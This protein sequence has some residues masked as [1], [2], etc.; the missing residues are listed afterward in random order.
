MFCRGALF[1]VG[2][3]WISQ[4]ID[5][6]DNLFNRSAYVCGLLCRVLTACYM[7]ESSCI[8]LSLLGFTRPCG[9]SDDRTP[10]IVPTLTPTPSYSLGDPTS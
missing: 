1:R 6:A 10:T 2:E 9:F 7:Q 4:R 5:P 8:C 3:I